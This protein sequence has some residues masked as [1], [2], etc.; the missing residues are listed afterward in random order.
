[1]STWSVRGP[2]RL[3]LVSQRL[4]ER[5]HQLGL[6]QMQV[7]ARLA[8]CGVSTTNKALSSLEHGAGIDVGRLP[9]LAAALD[10][11]VTYLLGLTADPHSWVPDHRVL[12]ADGVPSPNGVHHAAAETLG[13][14]LP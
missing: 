7:V 1:M 3:L 11:T 4:R 12:A 9:E 14:E 6:T 8:R 5:R 2:D 10:C 13:G